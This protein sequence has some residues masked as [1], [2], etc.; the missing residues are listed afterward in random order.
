V[1]PRFRQSLA[2]YGIDATN[3]DAALDFLMAE[4]GI[5]QPEPTAAMREFQYAQRNPQFAEYQDRTNQPTVVMQGETA[6]RK[7]RGSQLAKEYG[8]IQTDAQKARSRI[9]QLRQ[10]DSLL[11]DPAVYTGTGA[12][13]I[14][15][16]KRAGQT[17]FGMDFQGVDKAEAARRVV[18]EMALSFKSDLPG[19]MSDSDRQFLQEIPPN[20]GDTAQGRR[21][22]VELMKAKEQRKIELAEM[23]RNYAR[24][25]GRLDDGWYE[26]A[27]RYAERNPMFDSEMMERAREVAATAEQRSPY[28]GSYPQVQSAEDWEALEPGDYYFDPNGRLKQK[29]AR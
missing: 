3:P 11:S 23:A 9:G 12:Q 8:Q 10:I 5:E 1:H 27:A 7:E 16:L 29:Q 26:V 2:Q 13:T 18:N 20:I 24:Q 21:L 19:P 25:T 15:A 17:L 6:Y 22:L 4:A 28:A 14:N